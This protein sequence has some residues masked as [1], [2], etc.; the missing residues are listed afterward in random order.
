MSCSSLWEKFREL[1]RAAK[2]LVR[3]KRM[4]YFQKL[5][6]LLKS[7]SK[8]FW[9]VFKTST[10]HSNIASKMTWT[11]DSTACTAENPADIANLLNRYF[12]SLFKPSDA[13]DDQSF[14]FVSNDDATNPSTISDVLLTVEEVCLAL[15][16][17]DVNKATGPDLIP[18][19]LLKNCA[20]NISPS[21]CDPFNKS[22]SSG[23]L[24]SEWKLANITP[25]PKKSTFHDVSNYRPISLLSLVSKVFERCIYNHLIAHVH[26]QIYELQYGFLRGRSTTSQMLYT[27][28][29]IFDELENRGQVDVV[30]LD[31]AKAILTKSV[32]ISY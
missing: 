6:L 12:Y 19:L 13:S 14:P 18:A 5:P 1:R 17:L 30:Y 20:V 26:Q 31:F 4:Q 10:K 32:M 23:I 2:S 28:N 25:I 22:L 15:N 8:K 11:Q 9:S 29:A 24:P 27:C 21:L 16:M 3:T 7:N